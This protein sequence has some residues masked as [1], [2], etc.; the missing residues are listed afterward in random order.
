MQRVQIAGLARVTGSLAVLLLTGCEQVLDIPDDPR[1][2]EGADP[3]R[4]LGKVAE[5]AAPTSQTAKVRIQACNFIS[6]NCATPVTGLTASLCDRLD[7]S[8]SNPV[9]TNITDEGGALI[10]DVPTGGVLGTGFDGYLQ[11]TAP[12]ELCTNEEVFGAS[13]GVLCALVG[14]NTAAPSEVCRVPT[15]APSL[16]FFNPTIRA[17]VVQPIPLPLLPTSALQPV[18]AE[19]G[20][21]FDPLTGTLFI[22]S[23]DCDGAPAADV[24]Y[25]LNEH[26]DVASELY[27]I[28]GN[29]S[30]T[31]KHTDA[32]GLGGFI[33]VPAGFVEVA[34]FLGDES[35]PRIGATAVRSVAFHV[36]YSTVA[37]SP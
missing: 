10:F 26:G 25:A 24:A 23:R 32:S 27:S 17:D 35:G 15:F 31:A 28:N 19:V 12:S 5:P 7:V 22:S 34:G 29:I 37:P 2:V 36:T 16:L 18:L 33:G 13:S 4:C 1:V 6:T 21:T 20:K 8:C 9:A 14:C 11:I 30:G 3:W